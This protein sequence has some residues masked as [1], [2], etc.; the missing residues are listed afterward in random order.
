MANKINFTKSALN[1]LQIP[2]IGKRA[3]YNDLKVKGLQVAVTDKG[4]K[5]FYVYKRIN[6]TPYPTRIKLG[7]YPDLSPENARKQAYKILGQIAEGIDP[8]ADKKNKKSQQ[9]TLGGCFDEY[10]KARNLKEKTQYDYQRVR[11]VAFS[12]WEKKRLTDITSELTLKRHQ[13]LSEKSP[14]YANV[15]MRI[16]HALFNFAMYRFE[17]TNGES[18]IKVNPASII[19]RTK[20]WNRVK[21][22]ETYIKETQLAD[23]FHAVQELKTNDDKED[24]NQIATTASDYLMLIILTGLRREEA[25]KLTWDRIDFKEK[26]LTIYE[27]KNS[28]THVLPL[29]DYLYKLLI[30]RSETSTTKY[31]FPGRKIKNTEYQDGHIIDIR[32]RVQSVIKNSGINFKIHDLRRTFATY[33]E[34]LDIPAYALKYL[35]NHKTSGDV[36]AGYILIDVE[37]VRK[38]M[39]KIEDY[40]LNISQGD[41]KNVI[42]LIDSNNE[43][44]V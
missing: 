34:R 24:S 41:K 16:L 36:T 28:E 19:A 2:D 10:F 17:D 31:V 42:Q 5:T 43:N 23:W 22:R 35:L 6:E 15:A 21:R 9:I 27:T 25:A 33:A 7:G 40:I 14:S 32:K 12:D 44:I 11:I 4:T 20:S 39:Q 30:K 37:R 38:P 26:T 8:R 13:K 18:I 3:Y 1:E 29:G